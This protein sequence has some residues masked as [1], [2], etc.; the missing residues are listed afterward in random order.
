[1]ATQKMEANLFPGVK[2]PSFGAMVMTPLTKAI[3]NIL[4]AKQ[5][6]GWVRRLVFR[7]VLKRAY[8]NFAGCHPEWAASLFDEQFLNHGATSLLAGYVREGC[9]PEIGELTL[10]WDAQF[11][12]TSPAV[13]QRRI[14]ELNPVAADFLDWLS[15]ELAISPFS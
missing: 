1:M 2:T 11:G 6:P 13:R 15:R 10:A 4:P 8:A 9:L 5:A 12:P 7:S 14:A 3:L